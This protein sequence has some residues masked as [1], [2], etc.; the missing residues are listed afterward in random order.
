MSDDIVKRLK[1]TLS[2]ILPKKVKLAQP[3][4]YTGGWE[5]YIAQFCRVGGV[6]E[7]APPLC[8]LNQLNF[9]SV[10]FFIEPDGKVNLVASYDKFAGSEMVN[11][12]CFF[13]QTSLPQ[14]D[15]TKICQSVGGALYEKQVIGHVTI[16]L[17]SFPNTEDPKA[18]PFFWAIDIN[19]EMTDFAAVTGFFD[20]L[21][22][23]QLNQQTGEYA[24][25]YKKT[26]DEGY[27]EESDAMDEPLDNEGEAPVHTDF[28]RQAGMSYEPRS[29]MFC[30]FLNH[31]G[32]ASIQYKTFF[33]MCRLESISFDME[34]RSGSTFCLYDC[35][36]SGVIGMLTIGV[37]RRAVSKFMIEALN[38]I[39]N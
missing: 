35:L 9:P 26:A 31:S 34:S 20:I 18:H 21:M 1:Q 10:S 4:L 17:I 19:C 7:C 14:I 11:A 33:H 24:I 6:I 39:Q 8:A 5:Q 23:G 32:L 29:F 3:T 38:F 16:D 36:A 22:E 30:N 12:G 37:H 25:S 28:L 27:L 15:L 13:P 2:K